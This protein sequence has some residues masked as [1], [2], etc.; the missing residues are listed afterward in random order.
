MGFGG[1]PADVEVR[2]DLGSP[3]RPNGITRVL[4]RGEEGERWQC[5]DL[6]Q[7]GWPCRQR[8][9]QEVRDV[10]PPGAGRDRKHSPH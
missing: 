4:K 1:S 6:V 7:G 2:G 3:D 10:A 5:E 9:G 8:K